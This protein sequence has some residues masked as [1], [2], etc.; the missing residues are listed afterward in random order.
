MLAALRRD[1]RTSHLPVI[2]LSADATV[3][4]REQLLAAGAAEF[5]T[6]PFQIGDLVQ[7]VNR[8]LRLSAP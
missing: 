2:V 8:T 3:H 5:V 1:P 6:K 4:S 7:A